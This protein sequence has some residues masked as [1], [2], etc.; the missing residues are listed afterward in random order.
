MSYIFWDIRQCSPLK[1]NKYFGRTCRLHIQRATRHYISDDK[2]LRKQRREKLKFYKL[3]GS[4]LRLHIQLKKP[5]HSG[6]RG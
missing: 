5:T 6:D 3:S 4:G 1:V 2:T